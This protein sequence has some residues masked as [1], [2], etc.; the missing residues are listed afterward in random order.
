[1]ADVPLMNNPMTTAGDVIYGGASG[2][3][4]R[5]GVGTAGQVLKVNAGAT[6]V[7]WDDESSGGTFVGCSLYN[8]ANLA[9]PTG[10]EGAITMNSENFD[11]NTL[12][13]TSSNTNRITI[14]T[15]LGGKWLFTVSIRTSANNACYITLR[16]NVG[17]DIMLMV[18]GATIGALGTS[19]TLAGSVLL[20]LSQGDYI[21]MTG[22]SNG[23]QN[24]LAQGAAAGP[25]LQAQKVG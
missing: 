16:K 19:A 18:A 8:S 20:D 7:E 21:A 14:P 17:A 9:F 1:M 12:H 4:T 5:L 6:A 22:L 13:D 2:A 3:P 25:W 10:A 15:G 23:A 11:T 24:I